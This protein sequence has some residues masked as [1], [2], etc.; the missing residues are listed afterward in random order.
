MTHIT[1]VVQA[2]NVICHLYPG[3][4]F[5][6]VIVLLIVGR[7]PQISVSS[8][9]NSPLWFIIVWI[10]DS[11]NNFGHVPSNYCIKCVYKVQNVQCQVI[12]WEKRDYYHLVSSQNKGGHCLVRSKQSSALHQIFTKIKSDRLHVSGQLKSSASIIYICFIHTLR[13]QYA[14]DAANLISEL[15]KYAKLASMQYFCTIARVSVAYGAFTRGL[16]HLLFG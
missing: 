12:N 13:V 10:Q 1:W 8:N 11:Q 15:S 16:I 5:E 4:T 14:H 7:K 6:K 2:W 9:S 3:S